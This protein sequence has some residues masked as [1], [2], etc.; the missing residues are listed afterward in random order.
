M[1]VDIIGC[2]VVGKATGYGLEKVKHHVICYDV[3]LPS[4]T[5]VIFG[6]AGTITGFVQCTIYRLI[7]AE[8]IPSLGVNTF[9]LLLACL[10]ALSLASLIVNVELL[11]ELTTLQTPLEATN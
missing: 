10:T 3:D 2:G 6:I 1:N 8:R 4:T 11:K 9:W 7:R 5:T